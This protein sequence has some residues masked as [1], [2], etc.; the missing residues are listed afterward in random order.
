MLMKLVMLRSTA[1][2]AARRGK[3]RHET[4]NSV[5]SDAVDPGVQYVPGSPR[6]YGWG[7]C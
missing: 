4:G 3:R 1:G 5:R 2:G 7:Q 6:R